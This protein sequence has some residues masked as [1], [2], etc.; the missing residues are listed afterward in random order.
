MASRF[1][2]E[3]SYAGNSPPRLLIS[4]QLRLDRLGMSSV[5][6]SDLWAYFV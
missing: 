4:Q 6:V 5:D 2:R 1:L 3:G